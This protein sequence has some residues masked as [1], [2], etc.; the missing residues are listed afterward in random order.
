MKR[1]RVRLWEWVFQ[2][3]VRLSNF[4]LVRRSRA[5]GCQAC[6]QVAELTLAMQRA[7]GMRIVSQ[8]GKDYSHAGLN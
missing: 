5:C 4:A 1:L 8:A 7:K 2:S 6:D 3:C